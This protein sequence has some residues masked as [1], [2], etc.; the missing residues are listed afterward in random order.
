MLRLVGGTEFKNAD[1]AESAKT[2]VAVITPAAKTKARKAKSPVML[3]PAQKEA[4][5]KLILDTVVRGPMGSRERT[6]QGWL[7]TVNLSLGTGAGLATP[8]DSFINAL[9]AMDHLG[10]KLSSGGRSL[11]LP[12][13]AFATVIEPKKLVRYI[14]ELKKGAADLLGLPLY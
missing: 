12:L 14:P 2:E 5:R 6:V 4:A 13:E 1:G 11:G 9:M 3:S 10:V 8:E 7:D